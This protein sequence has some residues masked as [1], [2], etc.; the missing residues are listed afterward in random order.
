MDAA[1]RDVV[2]AGGGAAG[3]FAAAE[4]LRRRPQASVL[5]LEKTGQT[6]AKVRISGGGRCN[7]THHCFDAIQLLENYPRGNP[8]LK[9]VFAAFP[10]KQT[11]R[12]FQDRGVR[13][14]AESDGRMFPE[15]NQSDSIIRALKDSAR[16]ENYRLHL[17]QA[18]TK[19]E[20]T[21]TGFRLQLSNGDAVESRTLLLAC[22]GNP[23]KAGLHFLDALGLER[24]NA[25]PSLFTFNVKNHSWKDLMGL[26]A[27][28]AAVSLP[29]F[30]FS[31]RGPVLVTHWG[32]SGPA[33]LKLSAAA[34]RLLH[35]CDYQFEF[36][37]DFLPDHSL[38]KVA[39]EL[40][41]QAQENPRQKPLNARLFG[42]PQRLWE[43]L[44]SESG[45]SAY[46]NWAEAGKKSLQKMAGLLK[47]SAFRASGKTTFKEEFVTAGGI[48][49]QEVNPKTCESFRHP[50][51][52]FAGEVLDVDGF[53]G[54]FN[55]QAAWS[56]AFAA[57]SAIAGQLGQPM[58]QASDD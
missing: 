37:I 12:W 43:K 36:R 7:A 48:D 23:G 49:L 6:L 11:I 21:R 47:G 3:Y 5:M 17:N 14:V 34:A 39:E 35:A 58:V 10:V 19:V 41:R 44:C 31:F 29:D 57:A 54:G 25:V 50:G 56:T 20:K 53:T 33:V 22:G 45:L 52:Y 28:S 32:F 30:G 46:H 13:L 27:E 38:D 4:I 9:E 15:S 8:W 55:F 42:L 1:I 16:G 18:L 51:L 40:K 2:I 26:S 24:V